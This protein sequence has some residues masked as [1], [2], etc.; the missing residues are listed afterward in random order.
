MV[1]LSGNT[2]I[3]MGISGLKQIT[4]GIKI[5]K[6]S[7]CEFWWRWLGE[8]S[9]KSHIARY[10][11]YKMADISNTIQSLSI[12]CIYPSPFRLQQKKEQKP[13]CS[14]L[15]LSTF[16]WSCRKPNPTYKL[17]IISIFMTTQKA[18]PEFPPAKLH[19]IPLPFASICFN[20]DKQ[21]K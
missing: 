8:F 10:E 9:K 5:E 4:I 16:L 14:L 2:K 18:T 11:C 1:I 15:F 13:Y 7:G 12:Y 3:N 6:T 19:D 17:L 20:K 21:K